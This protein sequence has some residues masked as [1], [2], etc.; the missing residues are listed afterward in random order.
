[1]AGKGR[2]GWT[3]QARERAAIALARAQLRHDA[4][5][6]FRIRELRRAPP[7]ARARSWR[8]IAETL[9]IEGFDP[10]GRGG[11]AGEWSGNAVQRIAKRNGIQ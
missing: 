4:G 11:Q 6:V 8:A 2:L 3:P 9:R 5:V 7:G 10:P 1:M